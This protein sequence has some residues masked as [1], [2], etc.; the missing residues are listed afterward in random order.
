MAVGKR[1]VDWSN[2]KWRV[3]FALTNRTGVRALYFSIY[4]CFTQRFLVQAFRSE[5][6]VT[7]ASVDEVIESVHILDT[8]ALSR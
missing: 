6:V 8:L 4:M 3:L 7:R 5:F 2:T 1:R